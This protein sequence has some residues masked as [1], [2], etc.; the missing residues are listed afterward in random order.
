WVDTGLTNGTRYY[1]VVRAKDRANQ[2]SAYSTEVNATPGN[3]PA[4]AAPTGLAA[5]A[6]VNQIAL[7]WNPNTEPDHSGYNVWYTVSGGNGVPVKING[8]II[9][10][11][12]YTHTNLDPNLTYT[13]YITCVDSGANEGPASATVARQPLNGGSQQPIYIAYQ[14]H[15]HQPIYWPYEN[16]RTTYT[17]R[18]NYAYVR[19]VLAW[20]DR[21]DAY[22]HNPVDAVAN[23]MASKPNWG[24]QISYSGSLQENINNMAAASD[25]YFPG[26]NNRYAE[27][28]GWTTTLGNRRVDLVSFGYHHPLLPFIDYRDARLQIQMHRRITTTTFGNPY[29]LG[30]FP[31]ESAFSERII[32]QLLDEGLQ[33]VMVDNLHLDH[34]N[35]NFP[36]A[37]GEK[38]NPPNRA[39]AVNP[40]QGTYINLSCQTNTNY[41]VSPWGLR[42]HYAK[43]VNPNDGTERKMIIVPLE[44]SLGYDDSYGDRTP[45][46][47]LQAFLPH[48]TDP[49]HPL[50][51]V[52]AHDGDNAGASGFRYYVETMGWLAG[53]DPNQFRFT[54]VQ[55]YLQMFPPDVNDV[56][57]I[58]DGSWV[59]ADLGDQELKKWL[60]DPY[61]SGVVNFEQGFS[62]DWNSWMVI[63]AGKNRML[64]AEAI[65]PASGDI[66]GIVYKNGNNTDKAWA[67]FLVGEASC[68]WYWDGTVQWD[69]Q[70]SRAVANA[71]VYADPIIASSPGTDN[72]APNIFSLQREPYNPGATEAFK[73]VQPSDFQVFTFIYDVNAVSNA[74]LYY[75]I[76]ADGENPIGDNAN[77]IY[78]GGAGVGPWVALTM[79]TRVYAM[80]PAAQIQPQYRAEIYRAFINGLS[81]TLVDYYVTATDGRGNV[82]KSDIYHCYIGD[83]NSGG[84]GGRWTPAN[85][86]SSDTITITGDKAGKLHWGVN[87]WVA[88]NGVYWP[89]GTTT[90][91]AQSVES[92][93]DG[94]FKIVIGPFNNAAQAVTRVDFVFHYNDGTWDANSG[95]NY[96]IDITNDTTP[97]AQPTGFT[98]SPGNGFVQLGWTLGAGDV[99]S[100]KIYRGTTS[101]GPYS[102]VVS[103]G[104]V[105]TY[106]DT[107]VVNATTY[108]YVLR[109]A[110]ATGNLSD[111]TTQISA[112]PSGVDTTPPA[113]PSNVNATASEFGA[114]VSWTANN[115]YDLAGY[116]IYRSITA[117]SSHVLI[118][119]TSLTSR[120]HSGLNP[121]DTYY[122]VIV[123]FD[124]SGN[125]SDT[126]TEKAIKPLAAQPPAAP[127]GVAITAGNAVCTITWNA[128]GEPDLAG[129]N[130]YR[131]QGS[132]TAPY[133]KVN[134]S[135]VVVTNYA[136]SGLTNDT[137]YY[138]RIRAVD[139]AGA[140]SDSSAIVSATPVAGITVAFRV[141]VT[142][143]S[144]GV[145]QIAGNQLTPTWTPSAN[146]MT[147]EG[148]NIWKIEKTYPVG[149]VIQYKFVRDTTTWESDFPAGAST[150]RD[151]TVVD[152]GG[153]K[154]YVNNTWNVD[155]D[156]IPATPTGLQA[157]AGA[158]AV[159]LTWN[160]VTVFDL[161]GYCVYRAT[162]VGGPYAKIANQITLTSRN[163][164]G[165]VNG[166]TYYYYVTAE[167]SAGQA[168]GASSTVNATPIIPDTTSP[169]VVS[170]VD[171][172]VQGS[173]IRVAWNPNGETDVVGYR[174]YRSASANGA[175]TQLNGTIETD[176]D[177]SD[178]T[179]SVNTVYHY[180]VRAQD[181]SGNLSDTS[182]A[183]S[184][185][186]TGNPIGVDGDPS[187]WTGTGPTTDRTYSIINGQWIWRDPPADQRTDATDPD[188]NY[189]LTEVRFTGDVNGVSFL[190]KFTDISASNLPFISL[191]VDKDQLAGSGEEWF[192]SNTDMT[193]AD[194]GRR[195]Y[196]IVINSNKT[197]YYGVGDNN[198]NWSDTGSSFISPGNNVI[199]ANFQWYSLGITLPKLVRFTMGVAQH[200]GA[201]SAAEIFGS[202][203]LDAV[204]TATGNT[205]T[206]ISDGQLD[207]N[208]DIGFNADGKVNSAPDTP[209]WIAPADGANLTS[210][211][212]TFQWNQS[213][214][215]GAIAVSPYYEIQYATNSGFT[216]GLVIDSG[217]GNLTSR[218][219]TFSG[220]GTYY[221]RV[222]MRDDFLWS[223]WSA[224]RTFSV[225]DSTAPD[226]SASDWLGVAS[227]TANE[228]TVDKGEWI[229]TDAN[230]DERT[231]GTDPDGNYDLKE[232]RLKGDT[233]YLFILAKFRDITTTTLPYLAIG[234]ETDQIYGNGQKW[235][236]N[237]SD[238][239]M[240]TNAWRELEL[241][242]NN[243]NVGFYSTINSWVWNDSGARTI[244]TTNDLIEARYVWSDLKIVLPKKLR[245]SAMTAENDAGNVKDRYN[246]DA[247]DVVTQY[248]GNTWGEV[249]D[250][251]L[252]FWVDLDFNRSGLINTRPGKPSL[253]APL[254]GVTLNTSTVSFQFAWSDADSGAIANPKIELQL[255]TDSAFQ[256]IVATCVEFDLDT[257]CAASL[258]SG[259]N[260]WWRVRTFDD[261]ETSV[262]SD[263]RDFRAD[264]YAAP[265]TLLE[266]PDGID[267][268]TSFV[269]FAWTQP[270][271]DLSGLDSFLLEIGTSSTFDTYQ[272]TRTVDSNSYQL[273]KQ[274]ETVY[275]WR[276]RA[277]D[278]AG[279]MATSATR[280]LRLDTS[281]TVSAVTPT[282]GAATN[283]STPT[284]TWTGNGS[285]YVFQLAPDATFFTLQ[286]SVTLP[287]TTYAPSGA[288]YHAHGGHYWR[289]LA[290][291]T[292][293]NS[294]STASRAIGIDTS[295][296]VNFGAPANSTD[297]NQQ[298]P[299]F[300]WSGDADTWTFEI[301]RFTDFSV[302]YDNTTTAALT[303][304]P[305]ANYAG[306]TYYWR[307]RGQDTFGNTATATYRQ[308]V[309]DTGITV[310]Q[311]SPIDGVET[312]DA[313]PTFAWTGDADT[314]IV[315]IA[316]D[317]GFAAIM[318]SKTTNGL[319]HTPAANY[320]QGLFYWRI[321]AQ[322]TA[323]SSKTTPTRTFRIDTSVVVTLVSPVANLETRSLR[324]VFTWTGDALSYN[325][326]AST[327]A[328]FATLVD[329]T[330]SS[331]L[332][333]TAA[334]DYRADTYYWRI[335]ARDTVGNIE[336]SPVRILIV[337]TGV[338]VSSSTPADG[339]R[340]NDS[341]P[342][343]TWTGT[344][345]TYILQV[346]RFTGFD[347]LTDVVTT[348][349]STY[350]PSAY[351]GAAAYH[352]RVIASDDAGNIETSVDRIV[353]IDTSITVALSSPSNVFRTN[354]TAPAF[355]W[356]GDADTWT[357]QVA[358]D[359]AFTAIVENRTQTLA[360][361]TG[362]G[363]S[364]DTY[365]WRVSGADYAGNRDTTS[366]RS[367]TVDTTAAVT[368]TSPA[369]ST[370]T[371]DSTPSFT[372]TGDGDTFTIQVSSSSTFATIQ[373]S[374]ISGGYTY[375][376]SARYYGS[377]VWYWRVLSRDVAGNAETTASR[378]FTVD[379][380]VVVTLS[381]P[382]DGARVNF[383]T[384]TFAWTG[385]ANIYVIQVS[386]ASTFAS[387]VD[388]KTTTALNHTPAFAYPADTVYW[389]I[390]GFDTVNVETSASRVLVIDTQV[391]VSLTS[392]ANG[393]R[394]NDSTP[395]FAWTGGGDTW[396][397]EVSRFS[398]FGSLLDAATLAGTTTYTPAQYYP[399]D[400]LYWRV[401]AR[402]SVGNSATTASRSLV[403]DTSVVAA[404]SSPDDLFQTNDTTPAFVWTG[405]AQTWLLQVSRFTNFSVLFDSSA[406]ASTSYTTTIL[407][408]TDTYYWRIAGQDDVGNRETTAYRTLIIDTGL[409]VNLAT[410][411]ANLETKS[412]RPVFSW[413]GNADTYIFQLSASAAFATIL[414]SQT[415]ATATFTP[416]A[417][418]AADT[419]YWRVVAKDNA[420]NT[421]TSA[422]RVLFIDTAP[423]SAPA[424]ASPADSA[425]T[426]NVI[427]VFTWTGDADS[428][429]IELA[430]DSV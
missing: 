277:V 322:K 208:F 113:K 127:T 83:P 202:D 167:D 262:W 65:A 323:G 144:P 51:V 406:T 89:S 80:P 75:R 213:D 196:E 72:I 124:S 332:I 347:T 212:I 99:S 275:Y 38:I 5:T 93:L 215:D 1:Y 324:P 281:V 321:R 31:A 92:P 233:S 378:T 19:D 47:R 21:V 135:T 254:A 246:A 8:A 169:A 300:S 292:V 201:G 158:G 393:S 153:G 312:N 404:L 181:A 344:G 168:S 401:T 151:I 225:V 179:V 164:S 228:S 45:Q 177:Y 44:R 14:W 95:L 391:A 34:C 16:I 345:E 420:G 30:M 23:H 258:S 251:V 217:A 115:E 159:N 52:L 283:D 59:G 54:T 42:P 94:T 364:A 305:G 74:T 315:E 73:G 146:P 81:N 266:P 6:G 29:S 353:T 33:W 304:Q 398:N 68:F 130:V 107:A 114:T 227:T 231:D 236:G 255:S 126:S 269:R 139:T 210:P 101:G 355:A 172:T 410:P 259:G 105:A 422:S 82:S 43:Y 194:T 205:W 290:W 279:N 411:A 327:S 48:N 86:T 162:A 180:R 17:T 329:T 387:L 337:D 230:T 118:E 222:R 349:A 282:A 330:I 78:A 140:E 154:M 384:P 375:T 87:G 284:Y 185:S 235:F 274:G 369:A 248:S 242:M 360:S 136:N 138:F 380:G 106:T 147:N 116:R 238:L 103:T 267:T 157:T 9:P 333:R 429:A 388:S 143:F 280:W 3:D 389:R 39:D 400:T 295:V 407:Y 276:V 122:Y 91:D 183:D 288:T 352:W 129:Y 58:T 294:A 50:L 382:A 365:Y 200:D 120:S 232:L 320:N 67:E 273:L 326:Q 397:I 357:L 307:V 291:D 141:N 403:I 41:N 271:D 198:W 359:A 376:P 110:D 221:S 356:T 399:A 237:G 257:L 22:T 61:Q 372:W 241:V 405:D 339:F 36:W 108:Y 348:A 314:Y 408:P 4:P 145:V 60:G 134:G 209:T 358:R 272:Q 13:Y 373:D 415:G 28:H 374:A 187:E 192:S 150:N 69:E 219:R 37:A 175:Y 15:M 427:T 243:N 278:R 367:F 128:N 412:L 24:A 256:T 7:S 224:T 189:D 289:V 335:V 70:P 40:P 346:S 25:G 12:G 35:K 418:R 102:Q 2:Y 55:D 199:E 287:G 63:T 311:T 211:L 229:W 336:T 71:M 371:S 125:A 152:Q 191:A 142:G 56:V 171:A 182:S 297:T 325:F 84:G 32:P 121:A 331:G 430:R 203:A 234:V 368:L 85:P 265:I 302:L 413:S 57:H 10:T 214:T 166:T 421:E 318:D 301:S 176:S 261:F 334:A 264:F 49:A 247:L 97:P 132:S 195:D 96:R 293:G 395:A 306:D 112:T 53:A 419:Y 165:L 11:A 423:P 137:T 414:D 123:A 88:P 111:T 186:V 342:T 109:S 299:V 98:S 366:S 163:D 190:G 338:T 328:T 20:P 424:L 383:V 354:S 390:V 362:A 249:Q 27:G 298:R 207:Y 90:Y 370:V 149:T 193:M 260:F 361:F 409:V 148:A 170:G 197:G 26:W 188:S 64:T 117:G 317:A 178:S 340:T 396:N 392:P 119:T 62:S 253:I 244:S 18:T 310:N 350:T 313:T 161:D 270:L 206:E 216:T 308:I 309:I 133:V 173:T 303:Y 381:T 184:A 218:D 263:T 426:R 156:A 223:G 379:T 377:G 76:D 385:D 100:Y 319:S 296:S 104:R 394:T 155:G 343:F 316:T 252:N 425:T 245:F 402:D 226:G 386:T 268:N 239:Q 341:T 46:A 417:D 351:Y 79:E 363:Y 240:D 286:D 428:Y 220:S 160:A 66:G 174:V 416:V 204:T 131:A 250:T 285:V 77:E